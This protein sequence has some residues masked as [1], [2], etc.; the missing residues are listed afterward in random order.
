MFF[1]V[2]FIVLSWID[3]NRPVIVGNGLCAPSATNTSVK[4]KQIYLVCDNYIHEWT[5]SYDSQSALKLLVITTNERTNKKNLFFSKFKLSLC[6]LLGVNY[7]VRKTIESD[8]D[9]HHHHHH[10]R[11]TILISLPFF[12]QNWVIVCIVISRVSRVTREPQNSEQRTRSNSARRAN[13]TA[14][15]RNGVDFRMNRTKNDIDKQHTHE[16][17]ALLGEN[18]RLSIP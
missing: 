6:F 15:T 10:H 14:Q 9:H 11:H 8:T 17:D 18:R 1:V 7:V 2:G 16:K 12:K 4:R 5:H 3:I 13:R